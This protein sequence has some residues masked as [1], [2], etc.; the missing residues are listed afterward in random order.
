MDMH[1]D[2]NTHDDELFPKKL[3]LGTLV[4]CLVAFFAATFC[5]ALFFSHLGGHWVIPGVILLALYVF[6]LGIC[7]R[8]IVKRL[9]VAAMML[10]TPIVPLVALLL[11]V[12]LISLLQHWN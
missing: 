6:V 3:Y 9:S 2:R 11:I 8:M 5:V 1:N 12:M 4:E 7:I 10:I